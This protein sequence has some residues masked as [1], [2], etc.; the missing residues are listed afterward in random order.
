M[1]LEKLHTLVFRDHFEIGAG[2]GFIHGILDN[3]SAET[4]SRTGETDSSPSPSECDGRWRVIRASR[5]RLTPSRLSGYLRSRPRRNARAPWSAVGV[6]K[7]TPSA[8]R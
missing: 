5:A 2:W 7:H 1:T 8:D 3:D 4:E 6:L